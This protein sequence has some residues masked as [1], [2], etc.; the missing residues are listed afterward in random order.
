MQIAFTQYFESENDKDAKNSFRI[1][2]DDI[3]MWLNLAQEEF[4]RI[5]YDGLNLQRRGFE[6][7]ADRVDELKNL[8]VPSWNSDA[9]AY[10]SPYGTDDKYNGDKASFAE[11]HWIFVNCKA[12]IHFRIPTGKIITNEDDPP[13]REVVDGPY[14]IKRVNLRLS[15]HDDIW[16]LLEDPFNRTTHKS[17]LGFIAES[18]IYVYTDKTFIVEDIDITYIRRPLPI[19]LSLDEEEVQECEL[20]VSL[21]RE[22]VDMAILMY[23]RNQG[24]LV[25]QEALIQTG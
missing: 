1:E 3:F 15:Q 8:V 13:V 11:N 17:P 23:K 16:R 12:K 19:V 6:E 22:I 21:H 24:R 14:S 2:S 20:P 9:V 7:S 5:R 10:D 25:P 18:G 4:V